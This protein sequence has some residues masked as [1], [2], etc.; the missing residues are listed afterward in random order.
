MGEEYAEY[1]GEFARLQIGH[2]V[3]LDQGGSS[4]ATGNLRTECHRCN[5]AIRNRTGAIAT[6]ASVRARVQALPGQQRRLLL[7]W[8]EQERRDVSGAE[9]L[10]FYEARQLP[11]AEQR[12][13]IA[14]LR[15]MVRGAQNA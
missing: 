10:L 9:R 13:T 7:S 6:A 11:P 12:G 8:L 2:W 14:D 1:P 3:P 15:G 4:T 5:G